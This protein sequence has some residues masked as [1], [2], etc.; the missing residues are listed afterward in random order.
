MQAVRIHDQRDIRI[1]NLEAP[2]VE[3]DKVLLQGGYTGICGT[4]L[5]LYFSPSPVGIDYRTPAPL[6]GACWPQILG[7]EFSGEVKEVG[8]GVTSV[9]PGDFVTVFPLHVCGECPA[10]RAD[11]PTACRLMAFEGINGRSGGMAELKLVDADS[12]FVLP[13]GVGLELGALVEPMAVAWHAVELGRP[14]SDGVAIVVGGG[15]IGLGSYFA[16]RSRGFQTIVVSEPSSYR[17]EVL[18]RVGVEHLVDPTSSSL[19]ARVMELSDGAGAAVALDCA[20]TAAGLRDAIGALAV[21]GQL[22]IVAVYDQPPEVDFMTLLGEK[23]IVQSAIYTRQDFAGVID[24]MGK[25]L[26]NLDGGWVQTTDFAGV[27][28]ALHALHDGKTMKVLVQTP[29]D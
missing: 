25:G 4:D 21:R 27:E 19:E 9:K 15:P 22:V 18:S 14:P 8:E 17:R 26:Y 23:R 10:C 29:C 16:L 13:A 11:C 24:A 2:A 5:H 12:C 20:G 7:H 3:R 1:E 28:A 6:T